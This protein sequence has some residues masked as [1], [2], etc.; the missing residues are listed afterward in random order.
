MILPDVNVLIYAHRE[1]LD[2]H[3]RYAQ[4]LTELVTGPEPFGLSPVV[5]SGFL[6]IVTN[7][8]VFF[9]PTP[10]ELAHA[11]AAGLRARPNSVEILPGQAHWD[12]FAHL[13]RKSEAKG[14]LIP[15]AYLAAIAIENGCEL[16]TTDGDFARFEGLRWRHPLRR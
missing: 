10:I 15:D 7:S 8:R 13:C 6:R 2:E 5:L 11:F 9:E 3:G 14:K 4:W 16:A 12:V 1:E